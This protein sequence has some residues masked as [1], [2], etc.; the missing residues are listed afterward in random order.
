[1]EIPARSPLTP[2]S[3]GTSITPRSPED[4]SLL[5]SK[6][7]SPP[8][9]L[10]KKIG[11]VAAYA[12]K[13]P[14][15]LITNSTPLMRKRPAFVE[16]LTEL[17]PPPSP[18]SEKPRFELLKPPK[19]D[20]EWARRTLELCKAEGEVRS[21]GLAGG[22]SGSYFAR[23]EAIL[24]PCDE[25]LGCSNTQN[26]NSVKAKEGIEPGTGAIR[27]VAAHYLFPDLVPPTCLVEVT[28]TAFH[29]NSGGIA[30][31]TC[32][33]QKLIPAASD[34]YKI[35]NPHEMKDK[36]RPIAL[37]DIVL[38]NADRNRGNLLITGE[39]TD[40][41][42][43]PIDHGCILPDNCESGGVFAWYQHLDPSDT[44]SPDE[45]SQI[46]SID[47]DASERELKNL[48]LSG[49]AVNTLN[50]SALVAR[51]LCAETPIR[52]IAMYQMDNPT[53]EYSTF[54]SRCLN[55]SL[56]FMAAHKQSPS[57]LS[58]RKIVGE[59][60]KKYL[61]EAA[62]EVTSF[63]SAESKFVD[64]FLME[65]SD[66]TPAERREIKEGDGPLR[67]RIHVAHQVTRDYLSIET[68][69]LDS[70]EGKFTPNYAKIHT[71]IE[72]VLMARIAAT[73]EKR[74]VA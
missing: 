67:Q 3:P 22:T 16:P 8:P 32:S 50:I 4:S 23:R 24:K 69:S 19:A 56:L 28:S 59:V 25:E 33:M 6:T 10:E 12:L 62:T 47:L 48:G 61:E 44:F 43:H 73:L 40:R 26:T 5:V 45:Q 18:V 66:L 34:F 7:P 70:H 35:E 9:E 15:P 36:L 41:K 46:R 42:A 65:R 72:T 1:M 68:S 58:S 53:A 64:R 55:R 2:V 63:V 51:Q 30:P 38:H 14:H 11:D 20:G 52:E 74:H 37:I 29:F 21:T 71:E 39:G 54:S 27:E 17:T 13:R 49:G 60:A 31:K 57:L